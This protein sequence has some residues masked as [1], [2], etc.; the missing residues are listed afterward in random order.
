MFSLLT[1]PVPGTSRHAGR[2]TRDPG[3]IVD[4]PQEPTAEEVLAA[5]ATEGAVTP[6]IPADGEAR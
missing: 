1:F 2:R 4:L 3:V 5:K 6:R